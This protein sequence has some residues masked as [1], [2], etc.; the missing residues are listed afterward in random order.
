MQPTIQTLLAIL[1]V[2]ILGVV[3]FCVPAS[4]DD[5]VAD[6]PV[7]VLHLPGESFLLDGKPAFIMWPEE[8][9]RSF[10]QPWIMYA[11]TLPCCPDVHEKWMHQQFLD[12]GIAVAGID[13]GEA[14]GSPAGRKG[15]S[16]LYRELTQKRGFAVKPSL[17]GRSRGGLWVSSWAI[18]NKDK[19]AGIA[20]IYPVFDLTT[21][22]N[23]Q[24]AAPAYE[25]T[26]QE[27]INSLKQNNPVSKTNVL[28]KAK[29]PLFLIHGDID[30]VV[31]LKENSQTV[32]DQYKAAGAED[33]AQLVIA[34][35]QGHNFWKGFFTCQELV[36]FSIK[37]A[38]EGAKAKKQY[39]A[40][41]DGVAVLRDIEYAHHNGKPL[42]LDLYRPVEHS[43]AL[44]VIVWV[45]GGGWKNGSKDRCPAAW[46]AKH[47]FAV[48]SINYR[49]IPEG[50]WPDQIND[51]RAAVRWLRSNRKKYRL[52]SLHIGAWGSSAGGHLAALMG[53]LDAPDESP[54]SRVQ[55]V[56]DF[57][58]PSDLLSMPYNVLSKG[59][60]VEDLAKTNGAK[61][62]G[63]TVRDIPELAQKASALYQVSNED[64]PFLIVHGDQDPGVPI[65]QSKKLHE[66]LRSFG[67]ESTLKVVAGAGHGGAEF[68]SEEIKTV[69]LKFFERHLKSK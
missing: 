13:V 23:T 56:C 21:Y 64:P 9:K 19:V 53:T 67:V 43:N 36:D 25:M 45:H 28:A 40:P 26:E 50:Q 27:L 65:E 1:I 61:L 29:I 38:K 16:R 17:L 39:L 5:P 32:F 3:G 55:A 24:R 35:Q 42:L 11:P 58:G 33:C 47:G 52:D 4:A 12:A 34:E 46:L 49:L 7:K 51:C 8:S 62:L 20:G 59:K 18:R 63:G 66:K 15:M 54:S 30:K 22:P 37:C 41:P 57:F 10:P 68:Q 2:A 31:P 6:D 60:T 48:A 14:Y 44:P 69:V